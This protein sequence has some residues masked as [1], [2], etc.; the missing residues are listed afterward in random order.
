MLA[1][2][3]SYQLAGTERQREVLACLQLHA[4]VKIGERFHVVVDEPFQRR[5]GGVVDPQM[6]E[7]A[8]PT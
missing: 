5:G 1:S 6:I 8:L 4:E 3:T 2:A 7:F